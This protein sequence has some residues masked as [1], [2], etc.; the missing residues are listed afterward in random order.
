MVV[1]R[2]WWVGSVEQLPPPQLIVRD[3]RM[4]DLL[5]LLSTLGGIASSGRG[6]HRGAGW[7][8]PSSF[9]HL[10]PVRRGLPGRAPGG[11][12]RGT[13]LGNPPPGTRAPGVG[14]S[15]PRIREAVGRRVRGAPRVQ[16]DPGGGGGGR[17][18]TGALGE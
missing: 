11:S 3:D 5:I 1:V 17:A 18:L 9:N 15:P 13:S 12:G 8:Q 10:A 16:R 6:V 2:G 7:W 4:S 14:G